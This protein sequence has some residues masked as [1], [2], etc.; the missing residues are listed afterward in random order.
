MWEKEEN[1]NPRNVCAERDREER[2]EGK[3]P[4]KHLHWRMKRTKDGNEK[5]EK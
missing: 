1:R 5:I 4:G 2:S 3:Q